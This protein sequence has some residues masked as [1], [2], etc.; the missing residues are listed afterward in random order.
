M[1]VAYLRC[2]TVSIGHLQELF[3]S[4]GCQ[5]LLGVVAI[6]VLLVMVLP[7][8]MPGLNFFNAPK[9]GEGPVAKIGSKTITGAD[10]S[11]QMEVAGK[12]MGVPQG[13]QQEAIMVAA[14]IFDLVQR[15]AIETLVEE[16]KVEV[17]EAAVLAYLDRELD[18]EIKNTRQ[19]FV[20]EGKLK[21]DAT[22][23]QFIDLFKKER[24][25]T[26]EEM[27]KQQVSQVETMLADAEQ[28]KLV[29]NSAGR[30]LLLDNIQSTTELS[31]E[32][33]KAT[34]ETL[35]VK[36]IIFGDVNVPIEERE[37]KAEEALA[38]I[39][40]GAKFEDVQKKHM[41][42]D[43][44]APIEI[45]RDSV[46]TTPGL[47]PLA[48]LKKG[49]VSDVLM[50]FGM[51][52]IYYVVDVTQK[53]PE[54][55]EKQKETY[56]TQVI[57]QRAQTELEKQIKEIIEKRSE[58]NS[59]IVKGFYDY[60]AAQSDPNL[61]GN[62]AKTRDLMKE[63]EKTA[64]SRIGVDESKFQA[65]DGWA[66]L[67]RFAAQSGYYNLMTE[68]EKSAMRA[69]RLEAINGVLETTDDAMLRL[70]AYELLLAEG[71]QAEAV[72]QLVGAVEASVAF[73]EASIQ[74]IEQVKSKVAAAEAQKKIDAET[75][76]VVKDALT[77]WSTEKATFEK[78]QKELEAEEE[79]LRK[80]AEEERKRLEEEMK[81]EEAAGNA[82]ANVP[83]N[84][85]ANSPATTGGP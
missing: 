13:A 57:S 56:R 76:K 62:M 33:L 21:A 37:K 70:E 16:R 81:Q 23:Q 1:P 14:S 27:K 54:D 58:W 84:T 78:E 73:D 3:K 17:S 60:A 32:E 22:D 50:Q 55:F 38:E 77:T 9:Q 26:P 75:L 40:G 7:S 63:I 72:E 8:A 31:D 67:L 68:Q 41:P 6:L 83:S 35:S 49:E 28:A 45:R 79:K 51:P 19:T 59:P 30:F 44:G 47:E 10:L 69:E 65:G 74:V 18:R 80:E 66:Q 20:Q 46:R 52:T 85:P 25:M 4:K 82:P 2:P 42:G 15:K 24:G 34:Y 53:V 61:M 12:Q 39:R 29:M 71:N 36:Q 48:E 11:E 5:V 43:S 64:I